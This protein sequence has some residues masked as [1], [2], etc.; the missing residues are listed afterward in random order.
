VCS[1]DLKDPNTT[2]LEENLT[3]LLGLN[4]S[5]ETRG[6]G[7]TLKISYKTLDQLDGVLQRL[8]HGPH[9]TTD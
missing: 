2:A 7:G 9:R 3:Q 1:S 5:I 4:V 6:E 8:T